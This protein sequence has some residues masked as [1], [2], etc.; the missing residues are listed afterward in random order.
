[1]KLSRLCLAALISTFF[2]CGLSA[3]TEKP[4]QGKKLYIDN[5]AVTVTKDGILVKTQAGPLVVRVLRSD[6]KGVFI[7]ERDVRSASK[8]VSRNRYRYIRCECG[9]EFSNESDYWKH[10]DSGRCPFY[11]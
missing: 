7:L 1:M 9:A 6:E 4:H 11:H 8:G 5:Q 3:G 10:V 2:C